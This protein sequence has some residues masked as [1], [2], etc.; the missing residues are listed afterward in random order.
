MILKQEY[1]ILGSHV[2][3]CRCNV[4]EKNVTAII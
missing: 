4:F 3:R 1:K 2:I